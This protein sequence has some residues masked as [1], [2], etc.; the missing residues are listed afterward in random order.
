MV[1]VLVVI[2]L[3]SDLEISKVIELVEADKVIHAVRKSRVRCRR[4]LRTTVISNRRVGLLSS[5][6]H[7]VLRRS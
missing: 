5:K 7:R 3:Y 2:R 4:F 6:M 1:V